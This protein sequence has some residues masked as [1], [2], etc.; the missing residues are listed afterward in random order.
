MRLTRSPSLRIQAPEPTCLKLV[1]ANQLLPPT[2]F[3]CNK[4]LDING[5]PLK[6]VLVEKIGDQLIPKTLPYPL[7]VEI[8]VIDGDFPSSDRDTW[9]NDEFNRNITKERPGR[10]PLVTKDLNYTL[11]GESCVTLG[12]LEFTDNSSWIRSRKFKLAARVTSE[13]THGVRILEALTEAFIVK[14]QRGECEYSFVH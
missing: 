8:V 3:T 6:L 10:R 14:D 4:I 5:E 7:K 9:T 11:R 1:F 12:E 13:N 2:I